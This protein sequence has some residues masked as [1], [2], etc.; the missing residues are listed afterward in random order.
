MPALLPLLGKLQISNGFDCSQ[1]MFNP[2][3]KEA[4]QLREAYDF[5][6]FVILFFYVIQ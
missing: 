3:L 5:N 4:D 6:N 1:L 2:N